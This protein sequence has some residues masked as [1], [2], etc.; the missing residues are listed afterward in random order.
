MRVIAT[1]VLRPSGPAP[2]RAIWRLCA[3]A[4][5]VSGCLFE[6][7]GTTGSLLTWPRAGVLRHR[8]FWTDWRA[9]SRRRCWL[10]EDDRLIVLARERDPARFA[11]A[12]RTPHLGYGVAR[13]TEIGIGP[14]LQQSDDGVAGCFIPARAGQCSGLRNFAGVALQAAL[15]DRERNARDCDHCAGAEQAARPDRNVRVL[16]RCQR[17]MNAWSHDKFSAQ[18]LRMGG[19][20]DDGGIAAWW[21]AIQ[22]ARLNHAIPR[23]WTNVTEW[24]ALHVRNAAAANAGRRPCQGDWKRRQKFP[25]QS[26]KREWPSPGNKLSLVA[27][28]NR[29]WVAR[30]RGGAG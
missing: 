3:T 20:R 28:L 26:E 17:Y 30:S 25:S 7:H 27:V 12:P 4:S 1:D 13:L 8:G 2:L 21:P 19:G 16:A 14:R 5:K 15:K 23:Q 9:R 18:K 10:S 6:I 24:T 11:T 22:K 29:A